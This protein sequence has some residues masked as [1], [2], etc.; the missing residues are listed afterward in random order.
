MS[1]GSIGH[2]TFTNGGIR[3]S[4]M[5]ENYAPGGIISSYIGLKCSNC[6]INQ[7]IS[8]NVPILVL[9][10]QDGEYR[11]KAQLLSVPE[12]VTLQIQRSCSFLSFPK[13]IAIKYRLLIFHDGD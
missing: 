8:D 11:E 2:S 10:E 13:S 5:S 4:N 6:Q 3:K 7:S 9:I 1:S 12:R